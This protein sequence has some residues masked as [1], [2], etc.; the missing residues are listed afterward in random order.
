MRIGDDEI[1]VGRGKHCQPFRAVPRLLQPV[2]FLTEHGAEE[3]AHRPVIVDDQDPFDIEWSPRVR[4]KDGENGPRGF[5]PI[6]QIDLP[7]HS[8]HRFFRVG[9]PQSRTIRLGGMEGSEQTGN[10]DSGMPG[11][12]SSMPGSRPRGHPV[13]VTIRRSTQSSSTGSRYGSRS[14]GPGE[15]FSGLRQHSRSPRIELNLPFPPVRLPRHRLVNEDRRR[16]PTGPSTF[17]PGRRGGDR[18]PAKTRS[19]SSLAAPRRAPSSSDPLS[20]PFIHR[21]RIPLDAPE[22]VPDFMGQRGV[23]RPIRASRSLRSNWAS[24]RRCLGKHPNQ[25]HADRPQQDEAPPMIHHTLRASERM[26]STWVVCRT[27]RENLRLSAR[28]M[29]KIVEFCRRGVRSPA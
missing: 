8:F 16:P 23:I 17:P 28:A 20:P 24:R 3:G 9:Q 18:S 27:I 12:L 1:E 21:L 11:P 13:R 14:Q 2:P 15:V 10:S 25:G 5:L 26:R 22:S 29:K 6:R 7:V 4:K 19:A